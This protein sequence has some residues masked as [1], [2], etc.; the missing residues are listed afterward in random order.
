MKVGFIFK[1]FFP[2]ILLKIREWSRPRVWWKGLTSFQERCQEAIHSMT[3]ESPEKML[4]SS[5]LCASLGAAVSV[6]T[7][8]E[9]Q[10]CLRYDYLFK[11]C[12]YELIILV[13]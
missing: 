11:T 12:V 4:G 7:V 2:Q 8:L 1:Y 5:A 10:V 9:T 13:S 6:P 3:S